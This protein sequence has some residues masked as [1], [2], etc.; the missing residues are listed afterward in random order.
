VGFTRCAWQL[1]LSAPP[2]QWQQLP[3]SQLLL[4]ATAGRLHHANLLA[5][6]AG[7]GKLDFARHFALA[8]VCDKFPES[9]PCGDCKNCKMAAGGT[10]PD[11]YQV[12]WLEKSTVISVDQIR[13]LSD[14]LTLTASRGSHRV[15]VINRA[16]SMTTA[17]SNS[18]LKTLEEPGEGCIILL[19]ADRERELPVTVRSRCQRLAMTLPVREESLQ[20]L[21]SQGVREAEIAL[22]IANGAPLLAQ[23]I[24]DSE[25]LVEI[26]GLRSRWDDFV[27]HE[28]S[29]SFHA[30]D[31]RNR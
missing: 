21:Q 22:D 13:N 24:N 23:S 7:V 19:L 26:A 11:I 18:L 14:K 3:W 25:N 29:P 30:V 1:S 17:A 20:W 5:G 6:P 9:A 15:A 12:D 10:H 4:A 28:G 31:H 2:Y 27:M 8:L 16:H